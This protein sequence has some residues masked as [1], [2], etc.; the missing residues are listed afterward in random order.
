MSIENRIRKVLASKI[1]LHVTRKKRGP[2][3][4]Y[5]PLGG[6]PTEHKT[7]KGALQCVLAQVRCMN[8]IDWTIQSRSMSK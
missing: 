5:A 7:K 3:I 8:A 2:F 1:G 4:V 6:L